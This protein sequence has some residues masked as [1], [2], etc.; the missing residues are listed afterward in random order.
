M[1]NLLHVITLLVTCGKPGFDLQ[2][3][4]FTFVVQNA[5]VIVYLGC[6][7]S[8]CIFFIFMSICGMRQFLCLSLFVCVSETLK[9]YF[10]QLNLCK[11][12]AI[13]FFSPVFVDMSVEIEI[14]IL[15]SCCFD[16]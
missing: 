12:S 10:K 14:N 9:C 11:I 1:Q 5:A 6:L 13:F 7:C 3:N 4:G 2:F 8:L 15:L 16:L